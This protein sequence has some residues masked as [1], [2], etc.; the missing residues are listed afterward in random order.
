[1]KKKLKVIYVANWYNSI[2]NDIFNNL[3]SDIDLTMI[4]SDKFPEYKNNNYSVK[5]FPTKDLGDIIYFWKKQRNNFL[6]RYTKELKRYIIKNKPDIVMT[7]LIY[8]PSTLQLSNWCKELKI[9]FI[10]QSE[11]KFLPKSFSEKILFYIFS[12]F[13]IKK[14]LNNAIHIIPWVEDSKFF[15]QKKYKLSSKNFTVIP[16]GVDSQKFKK[17]SSIKKSKKYKIL[18]ISRLIPYKRNKDIINA[19]KILQTKEIN[20]E[21]NFLGKGSLEKELKDLVKQKNLEKKVNFLGHIPQ[22]EVSKMINRHDVLVLSSYNEAIGICV[23]EAMACGLPIIISDTCGAK[24]YI[25]QNKNG[26]IYPTG[27]VEKLS[28]A[29]IKLSNKKTSKEMGNLSLELVKKEFEIKKIAKK[30]SETLKKI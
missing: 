5:V 20:F 2:Y 29:L 1:M 24:V 18:V 27:D 3:D 28:K 4:L 11:I 9:K 23:V 7:N 14:M 22:E 21:V 30:F 16:P 10:I 15:L 19:V 8:L 25:K 13:Y 6:L 17:I 26:L 12:L